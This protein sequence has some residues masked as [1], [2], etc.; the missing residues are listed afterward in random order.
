M[1]TSVKILAN[2]IH[3]FCTLSNQRLSFECGETAKSN[4]NGSRCA[5]TWDERVYGV[6]LA[7]LIQSLDLGC[8]LAKWEWL[9]QWRNASS[10]LSL[11]WMG[12]KLL[13]VK[14]CKLNWPTFVLSMPITAPD[15][16]FHWRAS[17]LLR[18]LSFDSTYIPIS[19]QFNPCSTW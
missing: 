3:N 4:L 6:C 14:R 1:S 13:R 11:E 8:Q 9:C 17:E 15:N 12:F 10:A 2:N 18:Q 5:P 7:K 16:I 19:G